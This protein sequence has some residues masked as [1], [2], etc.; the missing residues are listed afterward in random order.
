MKTNNERP[1][2]MVQH[3]DGY[4]VEVPEGRDPMEFSSQLA[5]EAFHK[6]M[7]ENSNIPNKPIPPVSPPAPV[8]DPP[9][10]P[11]P[12]S[13]PSLFQMA[14]GFAKDLAKYVAE[15]AP[16]VTSEE[17]LDRLDACNA[18]PHLMKESMRCGLCGCLIEHK[19]KWKTTECPDSPTRW[20]VVTNCGCKE[21][22]NCNDKRQE[23]DNT[24]TGN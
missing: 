9:P 5:S 10:P 18:C 20:K 6:K 12:P 13:P 4:M 17:Y 1:S 15:G 24:K 8:S 3:P 7:R 23:N 11:P 22:C 14:R 21:N 16:N 2:M 19:A